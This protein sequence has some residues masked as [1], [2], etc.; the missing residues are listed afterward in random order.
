MCRR[1]LMNGALTPGML[2]GLA[3]G[4]LMAMVPAVSWAQIPDEFTN[5]QVLPKEISKGELMG[6]MRG[7]AGSLG[8]RCSHCHDGPDNLQGMDFATDAKGPKK[9]ARQMMR[10][11]QAVNTRHL[12]QIATGRDQ[13]LEVTC[14]T[15]HRGLTLPAPIEDLVA[16]R[17]ESDGVDGALQAYRS[18]REEHYGSASYD[19]SPRPLNG[20]IEKLGRGQKLAEALAVSKLNVELNPDDAYS[21][22]VLASVH[23]ELGQLDEAIQAM[24][25]AVELDPQNSWARRQLEA[26]RSA[27]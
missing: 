12:S 4:M 11:V 22:M 16:A 24:Q 20:L 25:K 18:L 10:M 5:L 23:R 1:V 15:C 9:V 21:R 19:F 2:A 6:I 8:V 7:Y 14:Q 13:R 17:I 27:R 3:V 26:L